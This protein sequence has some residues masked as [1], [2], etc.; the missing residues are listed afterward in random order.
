MQ[1]LKKF[2][3][4]MT[5]LA[6]L[7]SMAS[8]AY[9]QEDSAYNVVRDL[10]A[11]QSTWTGYSVIDEMSSIVRSNSQNHIVHTQRKN[12]QTGVL[13]HTF[14]I[15]DNTTS[16]ERAFRTYFNAEYITG[17][18]VDV[19]DMR[20]F[21]DV[22]YFCG[23]KQ[24]DYVNYL[25]EYVTHGIIGRFVPREILDGTG[26]MEYIEVD[27]TAH[28]TRLAISKTTE[29]KALVSAIGDM[30]WT[31]TA[32]LVEATPS[33]GHAW[34]LRLDTLEMPT[35]VIFSD[36]MTMRDSIRLLMQY[37]CNNDLP[38][39]SSNYDT[40]HQVFMLD[41]FGQNGC[42]ASYNSSVVYYLAYYDMSLD[43]DYYFH[44]NN[45]PMRFSHLNDSDNQFGVAFGVE[46]TDGIHGGLRFFPFQQQF[47]YDSCIYYRVGRKTEI[48]DAGNLYKTATVMLLSKDS[49]HI[50]GVATLPKLGTATHNV[51]Q[52]SADPYTY[53]MNSFTQKFVGNHVDIS[54]H[55]SHK[56]LHLFNQDL[57]RLSRPS[58]FDIETF[59][60]TPL[61]GRRA[62]KL[63]G[64]W[65][66]KQLDA[67]YSTSI[68]YYVVDSTKTVVCEE[69][70]K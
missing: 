29:S 34:N 49:Q 1:N 22:C 9:A 40:R 6:M 26:S 16:P 62:I 57:T 65:S 31:G 50:N 14:V 19:T 17:W 15:K 7:M 2:T 61:I 58:C 21:D 32:C 20:L 43:G 39:G 37:R 68:S 28:L 48:K 63:V 59:Q 30:E 56:Y 41:C 18:S 44:Y 70:S 3:T 66:F 12:V 67:L 38:V 51:T 13:T 52:L 4:L 42:H 27:E 8:R 55:N 24:Y 10:R 23:T 5:A 54:G 53:T 45:A 25:G 47:K 64:D 60:Y 33:S 36:I 35:G 11:C 69:C 46:E